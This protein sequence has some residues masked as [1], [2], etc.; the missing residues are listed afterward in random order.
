MRTH[1]NPRRIRAI[2]WMVL[3]VWFLALAAGMAN[4]CLLE[5]PEPHHYASGYEHGNGH[6]HGG[7]EGA[8]E[9]HEEGSQDPSKAPC[10]K[11]CGEVNQSAIQKTPTFA[12]DLIGLPPPSYTAWEPAPA[13]ALRAIL[14]RSP[15]RAHPQPPAWLLFARLAL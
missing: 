14:L 13:L 2:A 6:S 11:L 8:H 15:Q 12:F 5:S 1:L 10:L 3:G 4:A 7:H 9:K